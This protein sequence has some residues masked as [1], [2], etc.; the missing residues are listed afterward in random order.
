MRIKAL[1]ATAI[2]AA[3]F[4]ASAAPASAQYYPPVREYY[5]PRE[6]GPRD[7][8][9]RRDYGRPRRGWEDDRGYYRPRPRPVA[10][11]NLCVTSRGNCRT[12]PGPSQ[13]PCQ[14]FIPGFGPKR[15]AILARPVY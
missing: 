9:E 6:Y 3:G 7:Q 14:C 10:I 2:L 8:Y 13:S 1:A 12:Q 5:G 15:G 11:G 4:L